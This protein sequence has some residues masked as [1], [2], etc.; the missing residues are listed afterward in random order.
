MKNISIDLYVLALALAMM[1]TASSYA[2]KTPWGAAG[3]GWGH[4]TE[5]KQGSQILAATTNDTFG[6]QTFGISSGTSNCTED[7]TMAANKAVPAY[8]EAN[9][10]SLSTD[11]A[12][13]NGETLAGLSH[14]MGCDNSQE[15]AGSLQKNYRQIFPTENVPTASVTQTMMK[16]I[17]EDS[18]LS[19]RH[20]I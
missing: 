15:L 1:M 14:V 7:G 17:K 11:I 18:A 12:R 9:R 2:D 3:C 6:T 4:Q 10:E 19:C 8:I 16:V 5:G 20:A 13:G